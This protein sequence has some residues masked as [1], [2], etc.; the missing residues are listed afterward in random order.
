MKNKDLFAYFHDEMA[1]INPA[2]IC[3]KLN[4]DENTK[5]IKTKAT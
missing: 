1:R 5:P 3:H 4:I 2:F